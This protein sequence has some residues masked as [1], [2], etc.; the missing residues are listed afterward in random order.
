M[1]KNK[2][3]CRFAM[4]RS[5]EYKGDFLGKRILVYSNT[6]KCQEKKLINEYGK[7]EKINLLREF[8]DLSVEI[9]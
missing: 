5:L 8:A 4:N 1:L 3:C 9:E 6:K 7:F 2:S